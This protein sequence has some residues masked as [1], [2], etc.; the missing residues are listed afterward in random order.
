[1]TKYICK[2]SDSISMHFWVSQNNIFLCIIIFSHYY[3][4]NYCRLEQWKSKKYK[5]FAWFKN[6][7]VGLANDYSNGRI[8]DYYYSAGSG[9]IYGYSSL[10]HK[11][12]S[13]ASDFFLLL[14]A[15]FKA[16][17]CS[18]REMN[19]IKIYLSFCLITRKNCP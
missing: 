18:F 3:L 5:F 6:P 1:M 11:K 15:K 14:S 10:Y 2:G 12:A 7:P 9:L 4:W 17:R 8:Y 16:R 19:T 13:K